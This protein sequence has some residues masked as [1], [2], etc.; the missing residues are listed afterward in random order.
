MI[1]TARVLKGIPNKRIV[2]TGAM[3]PANFRNSDAVFN[4]G[5]AIGVVQSQAVPGTWIAM[6]GRIFDPATARKNRE[7]GVFEAEVD[8]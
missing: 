1:D 3:Q 2:L 6:S 8:K 7:R 4:I 5:F